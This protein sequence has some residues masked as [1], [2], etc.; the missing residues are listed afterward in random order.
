MAK[1]MWKWELVSQIATELD[2]PKTTVHSVINEFIDTITDEL[3]DGNEVGLTGFGKF[4]VVDT[5]ARNGVNPRSGEPI[6]I[7][8]SKAVKFRVWKPL[9]EAVK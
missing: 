2:L 8:A 1:K 3:E 7:A 5:K 4:E 9:K 6:K